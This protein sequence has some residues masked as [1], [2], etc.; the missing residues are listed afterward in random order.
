VRA[1]AA[2]VLS[3]AASAAASQP[4]PDAAL[5]A[6]TALRG[7]LEGSWRLSTTGGRGLYLF[8]LADPGASP[9]PRAAAPQN[10]AVEGAWR[11]LRRPGDR[12]ASAVFDSIEHSEG[13]VTLRFTEGGPVSVILRRGAHGGWRGWLRSG[14]RTAHVVM[15]RSGVQVA[16]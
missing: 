13:S 12:S 16:R 11:D 5:A 4:A 7:P 1:L 2:I 9:D 10:P 15:E 3:L 14:A 8:E 6:A